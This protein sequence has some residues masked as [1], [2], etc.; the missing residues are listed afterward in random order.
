MTAK[1]DRAKALLEDPVLKEAFQ[2][3]REKYRDLIEQTPLASKDDEALH[4]IRKM[5]HLLREV[6]QNLHSAIEHGNLE[7]FRATESQ[8]W[9]GN[10]VWLK[11]PT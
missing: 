1:S 4:D 10:L 9:L 7:D 2:V 3:C 5:L 8:T 6:E 11:K